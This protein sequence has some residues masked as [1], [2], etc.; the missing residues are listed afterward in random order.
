MYHNMENW[1]KMVVVWF[2]P[3]YRNGKLTFVIQYIAFTAFYINPARISLVLPYS[4]DSV[5]WLCL[6]YRMVKPY[7]T[8][9]Q[10]EVAL[11]WLTGWLRNMAWTYSSVQRY[12]VVHFNVHNIMELIFTF[13]MYLCTYVV[14]GIDQNI[15][16]PFLALC[17]VW[18]HTTAILFDVQMNQM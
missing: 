10:L 1:D 14:C 15:Y 17:R 13:L 4:H 8:E 3:G 16:H 9:L 6:L 12:E 5:L 7:C 18:L 11:T 2:V